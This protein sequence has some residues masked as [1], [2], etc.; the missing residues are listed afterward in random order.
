MIIVFNEECLCAYCLCVFLTGV[1]VDVDKVLRGHS[2]LV[3]GECY[4]C[5]DV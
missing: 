4:V 3:R 5:R 2:L 1:V